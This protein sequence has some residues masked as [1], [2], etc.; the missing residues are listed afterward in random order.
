LNPFFLFFVIGR[1]S[2]FVGQE[3]T[4][5]PIWKSLFNGKLLSGWLDVIKLSVNDKSV[6]GISQ[7]TQMV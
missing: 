6:N 2:N 4:S 1:V 3:A 5:L 7:A